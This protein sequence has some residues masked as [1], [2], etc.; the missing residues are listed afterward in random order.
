M[1]KHLTRTPHTF[2]SSLLGVQTPHQN[3]PHCLSAISQVYRHPT[4]L[5]ILLTSPTQVYRH[6]SIHPTLPFCSNSGVETPQQQLRCKY[7]SLNTPHSPLAPIEVYRHLTKH[8]TLFPA[9]PQVYRH[10]IKHP[11]LSFPPPFW[12]FLNFFVS[13]FLL[14][15]FYLFIFV[16]F[17]YFIFFCFYLFLF[18]SL[19]F[20]D[21]LG[22]VLFIS[23]NLNLRPFCL[24][25]F[26]FISFNPF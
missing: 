21:F 20:F 13:S 24:F 23:I 17:V 26:L 25:L 6:L 8:P 3:T 16:F 18:V 15:C 4:N 11:T 10:L 12:R 1:Y 7:T 19:A 2:T 14:F 9:T 22:L 5:Q